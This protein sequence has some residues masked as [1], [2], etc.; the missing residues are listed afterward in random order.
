MM[1]GLLRGKHGMMLNTPPTEMNAMTGRPILRE[2]DL[3]AVLATISGMESC[4][5]DH[6]F[7]P[8]VRDSY[9]VHYVVSG[10]GT[11]RDG[12]NRCWTLGKGD[13]FLIFPG[14]VTYYKA[15]AVD[16]WH[17]IWLG[18]N[19]ALASRYIAQTGLSPEQPIVRLNPN[20]DP[21]R[22]EQLFADVAKAD[23]QTH[24]VVRALQ[25]QACLYGWLAWLA[26]RQPD[27][28][29]PSSVE[30]HARIVQSAIHHLEEHCG[31]SIRLMDLAASFNLDRSYFGV[32][33]KRQTGRSPR[34]Y[35]LHLRMHKAA[36]LLDR[37]DMQIKEVSKLVGYADPL[38]FSRMF[39]RV[40]GISP[41]E[42]RRRS[43][44]APVKQ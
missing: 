42:Y 4:A 33:F 25:L 36:Q 15:D 13:A 26:G 18:F 28:P 44:T 3:H 16:P 37:T 1:D 6:A 38:L 29:P 5:P 21:I 8:A 41:R 14:Q 19:G 39:C 35:L 10:K 34:Q 24:P 32:L 23:R 9:L 43:R 22:L 12:Q 31:G 27:I 17:Y 20:D 30:Q 11:F 2:S 40:S 7:G